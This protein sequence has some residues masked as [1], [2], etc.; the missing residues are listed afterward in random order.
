MILRN[1]FRTEVLEKCLLI[2]SDRQV[3]QFLIASIRSYVLDQS[4]SSIVASL[5]TVTVIRLSTFVTYRV[6]ANELA[7]SQCRSNFLNKALEGVLSVLQGE[8]YVSSWSVSRKEHSEYLDSSGKSQRT[9]RKVIQLTMFGSMLAYNMY[10][11]SIYLS[12][13]ERLAQVPLT[14]SCCGYG[15]K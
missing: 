10:T 11:R 9:T 14:I 4:F 15:V 1:D 3:V 12:N 2:W 13:R 5:C 8:I 6:S 7:M